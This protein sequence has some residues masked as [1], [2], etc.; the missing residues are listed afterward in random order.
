MPTALSLPR[1]VLVVADY[2]DRGYR[3]V[4]DTAL[5]VVLRHPNGGMVTVLATGETRAG[6]R[7]GPGEHAATS[8][9]SEPAYMA[10]E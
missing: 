2:E 5:G 8:W 1:C 10:P 4:R 6:D 7:A 3:L 9:W